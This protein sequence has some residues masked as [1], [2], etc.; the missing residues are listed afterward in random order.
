MKNPLPIILVLLL[1]VWGCDSPPADSEVYTDE[2][3]LNFNENWQFA[4]DID[5]T[6]IA[7]YFE[8]DS[9]VEWEEIS[10]PH[11]A[12]IEPLVIS[13]QQWQGTAFYR[14]FF[15]LAPEDSTKHIAVKI[16]AA[17]HE[18]AILD[19]RPAGVVPEVVEPVVQVGRVDQREVGLQAGL[20]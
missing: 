13:E 20:Q 15:E 3:T 16:G 8:R 19:H 9:Q 18:A 2:T 1:L 17:M 6:V 14:K 11:T 10:L 12:H 7:D 5:T 4:R